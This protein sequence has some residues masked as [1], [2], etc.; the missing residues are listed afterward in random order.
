MGGGDGVPFVVPPEPPPQPMK[1]LEKTIKAV[2]TVMRLQRRRRGTTRQRNREH[3]AIPLHRTN[4]DLEPVEAL[5]AFGAVVAM[6]IREL[7]VPAGNGM[8]L[9]W[10]VHVGMAL[11]V[12]VPLYV[13]EQLRL[14]FPTKLLV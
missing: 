9:L 8:K 4:G 12:L 3:M 10:K 5:T 14:T 2:I 11:T 6:V 1:R 7:T 13:T